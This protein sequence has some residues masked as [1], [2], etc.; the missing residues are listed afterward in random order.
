MTL[1]AVSRCKDNAFSFPAKEN[2]EKYWILSNTT[3]KSSFH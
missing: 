2:D 3:L 1:S